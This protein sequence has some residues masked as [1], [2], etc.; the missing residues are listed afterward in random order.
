[1]SFTAH[2]AA[3]GAERRGIRVAK[4][5]PEAARIVAHNQVIDLKAQKASV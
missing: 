3:D 2:M 1:M 4:L 5:Q